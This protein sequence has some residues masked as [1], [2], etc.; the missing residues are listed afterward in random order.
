[1]SLVSVRAVL[2]F[3]QNAHCI[4]VGRSSYARARISAPSDRNKCVVN[5][6]HFPAL[7]A[8]SAFGISGIDMGVLPLRQSFMGIVFGVYRNWI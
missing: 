6:V 4:I 5:A 2:G 3:F 8:C 1:M 7:R